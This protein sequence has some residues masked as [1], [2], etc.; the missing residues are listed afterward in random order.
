VEAI[1]EASGDRVET[2]RELFLVESYVPLT[3]PSVVTTVLAQLCDAAQALQSEQ[4]RV[5]VRLCIALPA[6]ETCFYVV[7]SG[8]IDTVERV[9]AR[10]AISYERIVAAFEVDAVQPNGP[11]KGP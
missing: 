6:D 1:V 2:R 3:S 7:E 10:A 5:W 4:E 9:F 11:T 8:A